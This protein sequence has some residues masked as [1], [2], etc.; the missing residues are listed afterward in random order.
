MAKDQNAVYI[1]ILLD[2]LYKK[3]ELLTSLMGITRE[4]E[5]LLEEK[6]FSMDKF[7]T[8]MEEKEKLIR[9]LNMLEDGFEA[10]YQRV[11]KELHARNSE[12]QQSILKAQQLI[13]SITEKSVNLQALESKNKEKL[14]FFLAGKRQEIRSFKN[15][16]QVADRY[17]Q[18]MTNQH[19]EGQSYFL[20]KKK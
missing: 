14:L 10:L 19:Q 18:N 2:T 13:R 11:E 5:K 12:Y 1:N 20:D 7:D 3:E 17:Q 16:S 15:S 4:Q 8:A 9:N 6:D